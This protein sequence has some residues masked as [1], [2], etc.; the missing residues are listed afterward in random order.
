MEREIER[1]FRSF[2]GPLFGQAGFGGGAEAGLPGTV[3]GYTL[4]IGADGRPILREYGNAGAESHDSGVREPLVDT[5]TNEKEGTTK[6]VAEMPGVE[7]GDISV[8]VEN[9][10]VNIAAERGDKKYSAAVP[11]ERKVERDSA[12]A[13]Y[14]NGILEV[15]FR[16]LGDP[17]PRGTKVEVQ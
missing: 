6:L 11:L 10:R 4:T 7:R 12:K 5:I 15:T 3:W 1:L 13:S 17:K 8:T 9:K 2:A 16:L 14:K